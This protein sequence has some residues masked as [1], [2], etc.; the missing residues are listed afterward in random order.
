MRS[1]NSEFLALEQAISSGNVR[2]AI[3][4][5]AIEQGLDPNKPYGPERQYNLL[6][7]C[8]GIGEEESVIYLLAQ[9]ANPNLRCASAVESTLHSAIRVDI[10]QIIQALLDHGA[11]PNALDSNGQSPLHVGNQD[12]RHAKALLAYGANPNLP[13][14]QGKRPIEGA[15]WNVLEYL[16]E[17]G[18]NPN[19]LDSE[20][21]SLL[22]GF[23]HH[24]E[25]VQSLVGHGIQKPMDGDPLRAIYDTAFANPTVCPKRALAVAFQGNLLAH[26]AINK[27]THENFG[28]FY[29]AWKDQMQKPK[30]QTFSQMSGAEKLHL[31][32][33]YCNAVQLMPIFEKKKAKNREKFVYFS[34]GKHPRVGFSSGVRVLVDDMIEM[35]GKNVVMGHHESPM[36]MKIHKAALE[37]TGLDDHFSMQPVRP[38]P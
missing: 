21:H 17:Q 5:N 2:L 12:V 33:E 27:K 23:K 32:S 22:H 36:I 15:S 1:E 3:V 19:Q 14:A 38:R 6:S 29:E 24:E 7:E 4:Q 35:I 9:G 26:H 11:D 31:F 10:P 18:V 28:L 16:L 37:A 30:D 8:V 34:L 13:D 20:G 25:I